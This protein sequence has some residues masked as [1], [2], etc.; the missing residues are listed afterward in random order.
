VAGR[1]APRLEVRI[2]AARATAEAGLMASLPAMAGSILRDGDDLCFVPRY[3]FVD[4]AAYAVAVDGTQVALK[5]RP[6]PT[7]AAT[8]GVAG[9]WPTAAQVPLNLLRLYVLFSA[10]MSEGYAGQNVHLADDTGLP[11]PGAL[12][13]SD[14][15]LWD[16][17]RQR[18][19]VLLDP[20]RIK[21]GLAEHRQSGYPLRVGEPFRVVVGPEFRDAAGARLR[22]PAH[23]R[24]LVGPAEH[25][26]VDPRAW[27]VP[28]PRAGSREPL[29]V[30]FDRPLDHGLLL[31]CVRVCRPAGQVVDGIPEPG[32]QERSWR[33]RPARPWRRQ[34]YCLRVDA[35]LE[36]LA[37]NSVSRI[38][39]RDLSQ[40]DDQP[41]PPRSAGVMFRPR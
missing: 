25:H 23:R 10:P 28:P 33:F 22:A 34:A 19:T 30:V 31:R 29:E 26:R 38:F 39:D 35:M 5:S 8:T 12:L 20:A 21:R 1:P 24:Y 9:I 4:G 16:A 11:I 3:G 13:P 41:R 36:D 7:L 27:A 37:G 40:P 18:L 32:P 17:S 14:Y 2:A 15:E 6:H